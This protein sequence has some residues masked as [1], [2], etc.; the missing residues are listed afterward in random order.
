[1]D[2]IN[3]HFNPHLHSPSLKQKADNILF[4][5]PGKKVLDIGC[6]SGWLARLALN[7]GFDVTAMDISKKVVEE[8]IWY[9][10]EKNIHYE[11]VQGSATAIPFPDQSFDSVIMTEVLEHLANPAL[12][13]AEIHRVLKSNGTVVLSVPNGWTY[14]VLMDGIILK[15]LNSEQSYESRLTEEF[16]KNGVTF[17]IDD[18]YIGGPH[19]QQFSSGRLKKLLAGN[20][21][22]VKKI[23]KDEFL[24]PYINGF[25][26]GKLGIDR[27]K[28]YWLEKID[29]FL[30]RLIPRFLANGFVVVAV[31]K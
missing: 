12:A 2:L 25:F 21:F 24:L 20:N 26:S 23:Y 7:R 18:A 13:L 29:M 4:N 16:K 17:A 22:M 28:L 1:M 15:F 8:N 27:K 9:M 14:G 31:K 5:L 3:F 11:I 6:G 30:A 10:G 19:L